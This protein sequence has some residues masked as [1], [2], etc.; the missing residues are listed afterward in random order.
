MSPLSPITTSNELETVKEIVQAY[1][2]IFK[3]WTTQYQSLEPIQSITS[4][5]P[6]DNDNDSP[7][8]HTLHRAPHSASTNLRS[9]GAT[10]VPLDTSPQVT[11]AYLNRDNCDFALDTFLCPLREKLQSIGARVNSLLVTPFPLLRLHFSGE[12]ISYSP[13]SVFGITDRLSEQY[14][15]DFTIEQYGFEGSAHWFMKEEEYLEVFTEDGR[16][17]IA[18]DEDVEDGGLHRAEGLERWK[19]VIRRVCCGLDWGR[20]EGLEGEER[21]GFVGEEVRRAFDEVVMG[22]S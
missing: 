6:T 8:T 9:I 19:G 22:D 16:W 21:W 13:H 12:A 14:I 15:A 20:I 18:E 7:T 3:I 10:A 5:V 2:Q 4:T 1:H 11:Q 17:R